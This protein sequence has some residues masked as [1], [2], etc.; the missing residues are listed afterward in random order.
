[1]MKM[2]MCVQ[3]QISHVMVLVS[4]IPQFFT[5]ATKSMDGSAELIFGHASDSWL[6]MQGK[7]GW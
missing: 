3:S 7:F 5:Q 2:G 6:V 1:M 4:I